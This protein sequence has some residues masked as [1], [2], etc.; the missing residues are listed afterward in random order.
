MVQNLLCCLINRKITG[1]FI[2]CLA[3][4]RVTIR[5]KNRAMSDSV[6]FGPLVMYY[7]CIK[8]ATKQVCE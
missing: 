6:A 5:D 1:F 7:L 8:V 4:N 2:I 3:K